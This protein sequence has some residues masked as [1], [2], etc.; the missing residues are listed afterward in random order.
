MDKDAILKQDVEDELAWRPEINSAHIG[1]AAENGVVTLS[2]HVST[3]SEKR[4]AEEAVKHVS[5]VRGVAENLEV[6]TGELSGKDDEI[7]RRALNS[8]A[9]DT[10][11][12]SRGITVSVEGGWVTL[13]GEAPWQF[14]RKA[15]EN[16]VRKLYGVVGVLNNIVLKQQP[17][18]ADVKQRIENALRRS[19]ELDSDAIKV[20]VTGGTVTLDGT[21]DSWLA[22]D[23]AEDAAWAAPGV[24]EVRDNLR[25][26]H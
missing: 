4:A 3:F 9:W 10:L 22:R 13:S 11:V 18:P 8:L 1:V 14:Q 21:V 25:V 7:A 2:G 17:Q 19:A 24:A 5:G 26:M 6:R 23:Q 20:S 12:P 15:A 16:A